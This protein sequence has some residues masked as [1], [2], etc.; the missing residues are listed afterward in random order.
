MSLDEVKAIIEEIIPHAF[1]KKVSKTTKA[2]N[3]TKTS[4]TTKT[5]STKKPAVKKK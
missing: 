2:T 4:K 3:A 1:A 5:S